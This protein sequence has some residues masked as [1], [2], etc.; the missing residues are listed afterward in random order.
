MTILGGSAANFGTPVTDR[1]DLDAFQRL[2]VGT[3]VSLFDSQ[4]R[5]GP[6][7][8]L[9]NEV[10][11]NGGS[12]VWVRHESAVRLSTTGGATDR[13]IRQTKQYFKY[14]PGK[15]QLVVLTG[16][17]GPAVASTKRIGYFDDE[18][19]VYFQQNA[20]GPAVVLRSKA[21]GSVVETIHYQADWSI[22]KLDGF[23][24]SGYTLDPTKTNIF[25][26]D[27]QWLGVGRVRF[28]LDL[29]GHL[30]YCHDMSHANLL[31][32]VYMSTA[33]L[34]VR[35]EIQNTGSLVA[36]SMT[37][38]CCV[39][40]SEG[41]YEEDRGLVFSTSNGVTGTSVATNTPILAIRPKG[42]LNG[43]T[44]RTNVIPQE[45]ALFATTAAAQYEVLLN[46]T[47]TGAVWV[48]VDANSAVQHT[49]SITS[50]VG[51][52]RLL[53]GYVAVNGTGANARG[54]A[55]DA[56]LSKIILNANFYGTAPDTF[57]IV[58]TAIGGTPVAY[59]SIKW[60]ELG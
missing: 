51:G 27:L 23:G 57:V 52:T 4:L 1:P 60:K 37:Q 9:W 35:Y 40:I 2:R 15:S 49:T 45:V 14:Q 53:N 58:A 21:S 17:L 48:D 5:F 39:V 19:G 46:P 13:A 43:L 47:L 11:V 26:I 18:N 32:T 29:G 34:P 20:L 3:P 41:G 44:N 56:L 8:L 42:Q 12:N 6:S 31:G 28:G 59:S 16:I 54:S 50:A 7:P 33:T 55:D 36:A 10:T 38:I 22:D 25:M 30:I 24:P